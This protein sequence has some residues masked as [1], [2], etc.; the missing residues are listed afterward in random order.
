MLGRVALVVWFYEYRGASHFFFFYGM[1]MR[2]NAG[3]ALTSYE[4]YCSTVPWL[5]VPL[6]YWRVGRSEDRHGSWQEA[7]AALTWVIIR[8]MVPPLSYYYCLINIYNNV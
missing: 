2:A 3:I 4:A 5:L 7:P 6:V 1:G 8:M